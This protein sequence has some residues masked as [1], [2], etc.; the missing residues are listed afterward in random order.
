MIFRRFFSMAR[1]P[2]RKQN[3]QGLS[4]P[5]IVLSSPFAPQKQRH[6]GEGLLRQLS[7]PAMSKSYAQGKRIFS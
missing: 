1:H 5:C 2:A 6:C 3:R 7:N 4:R